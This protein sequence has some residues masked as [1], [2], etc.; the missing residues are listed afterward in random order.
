M[1]RNLTADDLISMTR[2]FSSAVEPKESVGSNVA[3][4]LGY[5]VN[6]AMEELILW[7]GVVL[8]LPLIVRFAVMRRQLSKA[9]SVGVTIGLTVVFATLFVILGGKAESGLPL[10]L[11]VI[12]A[13]LICRIRNSNTVTKTAMTASPKPTPHS[14]CANPITP[15]RDEL[16]VKEDVYE[17]IAKEFDDELV[18]KSLWVRL[19][20]ET[21][22]DENLTKARYI[23]ARANKLTSA[24]GGAKEPTSQK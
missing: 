4:T 24:S 20:A 18:D 6:G 1:N 15:I 11:P 17:L 10:V 9:Q 16:A 8:A 13:Y 7:W 21:D 19:F 3:S 5:G 23:R 22:G 2:G 14:N 12:A